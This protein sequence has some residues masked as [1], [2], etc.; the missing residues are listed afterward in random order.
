MTSGLTTGRSST[1]INSQRE[2]K[3]SGVRW[4]EREPD[5]P[6]SVDSLG[7][8]GHIF[9][10]FWYWWE[11]NRNHNSFTF[12]ENEIKFDNI[13]KALQISENKAS[14]YFNVVK[15]CSFLSGSGIFFLTIFK[16]LNLLDIRVTLLLIITSN[17]NFVHTQVHRL[18]YVL[19]NFRMIK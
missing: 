2:I 15:R 4:T 5:C 7:I 16:T 17:H 1:T 9:D 8:R 14:D 18:N 13:R 10:I 11:L 6:I 12:M 3:L 19:V